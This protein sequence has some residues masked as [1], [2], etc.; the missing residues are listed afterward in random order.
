MDINKFL[1]IY[2]NYYYQLE[3][4]FFALEPYCAIDKVNDNA[5]ST[6][7][8]HLI[9]SICGEIDTICKRMCSCLDSDM[10]M[11]TCGINEYKNVL[12]E[13]YPKIA[14]EKVIIRQH[15]Y[16]EVKPWQ[17]WT[18]KN[19]PH[20]WSLYNKVKHHR[21][22][23]WNGKEAY[24]YANQK[25]TIEALC[26]LY[27]VLEYWAVY[28]YVLNNQDKNTHKMLQ[29]QSK[30]LAIVDWNC[31][32]SHFMGNYFFESEKCRA[33]FKKAEETEEASA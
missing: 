6:K 22:E 29:V 5:F 3:S 27:I 4:D 28:N 25:T 2:W 1:E 31:F 20:W 13:H 30:H 8:L 23:V 7:Y 16:R 11:N 26:A 14:G 9:L 15:I 33:Y 24:K 12:M 17:A 19:T 18:H 21:D 10:D 32:Y